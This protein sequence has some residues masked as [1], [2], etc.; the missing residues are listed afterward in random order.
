MG[1]EPSNTAPNEHVTQTIPGPNATAPAQDDAL[2]EDLDRVRGEYDPNVD[3]KKKLKLCSPLKEYVKKDL[4]GSGA[5]GQVYKVVHKASKVEYAMKEINVAK[6]SP[7]TL[8]REMAVAMSV[9]H[10][11]LLE[12]QDCYQQGKTLYVIFPLM[13]R[14]ANTPNEEPDMMSWLVAHGDVT[15]EE[16]AKLTHHVAAAMKYLHE[17]MNTFHRDLKPENVLVGPEGLDG[18]KVTDYG[19]AR[20]VDPDSDVAMTM[21]RGTPGYMCHEMLEGDGHYNGKVD[22]FA[23][24]VILYSAMVKYG[25]FQTNATVLRRE[26]A[27]FRSPEWRRVSNECK[28]LCAHMLEHD[29]SKRYTIDQVLADPWLRGHGF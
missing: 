28:S 16:G 1:N 10:Q 29:A 6:T 26:A 15:D 20:F 9:N 25:P 4:L 3:F 24:G 7:A 11:Y 12:M 23:L 19:L 13:Q 8:Q 17:E 2:N 18:L 14:P 5:F 21:G 22:V 27:D